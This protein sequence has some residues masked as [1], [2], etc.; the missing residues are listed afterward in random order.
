MLQRGPVLD[1]RHLSMERRS[2]CS[3]TKSNWTTRSPRPQ[4][5]M[6][7]RLALRCWKST[8]SV[9]SVRRIISLILSLVPFW[10]S[11]RFVGLHSPSVC[12][13]LAEHFHTLTADTVLGP[14]GL[15]G[16]ETPARSL[17]AVVTKSSAAVSFFA[18]LYAFFS[19]FFVMSHYHR[20]IPD[21]EA[22][23]GVYAIP[24]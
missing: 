22:G 2:T 20:V 3:A 6:Y 15:A 10:T 14:D 5:R 18:P 12:Y 8:E 4:A 7:H 13:A 16:V 17:K 1:R 24:I 11:S 9:S 23:M 21:V 19:N